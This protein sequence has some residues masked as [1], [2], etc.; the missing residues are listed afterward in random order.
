VTIGL[1]VIGALTA[2]ESARRLVERASSHSVPLGVGLAAIS[3]VVLAMFSVRKRAIAARIPSRALL[4]DGWLS[5][6]GCLLDVVTVAGTGLASGWQW[7]W[8]D[9]VAPLAV[10]CLGMVIAVVM[11]R[12]SGSSRPKPAEVA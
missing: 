2:V 11:A 6:T 8:A 5:A 10:T 4:A 12:G 1:V 9:P 7:W 3:V